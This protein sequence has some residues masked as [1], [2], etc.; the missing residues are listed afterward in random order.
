MEKPFLFWELVEGEK[1][2][3]NGG[4]FDYDILREL[5]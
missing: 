5:L 3:V 2:M 4:E 1:R